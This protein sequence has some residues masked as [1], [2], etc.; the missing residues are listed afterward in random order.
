[1]AEKTYKIIEIVGTSANSFSDAVSS[2]VAKAAKTLHNL[3]WFEVVE[4]RGAIV[5]GKVTE[6]QVNIKVGFRLD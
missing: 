3:D 1:M 2:G 4:Q 5:D 6:F